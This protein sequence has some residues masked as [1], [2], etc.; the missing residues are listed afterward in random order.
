M[1]VIYLFLFQFIVLMS[2]AQN[3]PIT[4]QDPTEY[5]TPMAAQGAVLHHVFFWLKDPNSTQDK[6][7]LKEGLA[8]LRAIGEVQ[9][10]MI[11]DLAS[12]LKRDVVVNDW[13]VSELMVFKNSADQDAY[14]SHPIHAAFVEQYSHLWEKVVV[15]DMRVD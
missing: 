12:T 2:T 8:T 15:Y 9:Q 4:P 10:L 1:K 14:Q 13:Q 3:Q 6:A 7:L 11:G 5:T